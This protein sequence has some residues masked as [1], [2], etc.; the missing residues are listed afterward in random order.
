MLYGRQPA[1]ATRTAPP[2]PVCIK[3]KI[4]VLDSLGEAGA[5]RQETQESIGTKASLLVL[6][7]AD[8]DHIFGHAA[9]CNRDLFPIA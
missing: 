8:Q 2:G 7:I 1:V 9:A 6:E 5:V 3:N 4:D